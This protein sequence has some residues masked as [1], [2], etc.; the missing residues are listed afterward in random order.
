MNGPQDLGGFQGFGPVTPEPVLPI[1][2]AD[3]EKR[4]F[5][6]ALAM[7]MTGS[8]NID[9]SRHARERIP[10]LDYW[11][12]SYYEVWLRGLA[13]LLTEANLAS[14]AEIASG[15]SIGPAREVQRVARAEDI[16]AILAK[17]GP[18]NRPTA[19]PQLFA[20]GSKVRTINHHTAA[21]TRLPRYARNKTGEILRVHG[22]H[23]LPDSS[24]HGQD[25]GATWLYS[26][27]FTATELWGHSTHDTVIIDLWQP[28]LIPA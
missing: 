27:A 18:A 16:P 2:H 7:G 6:L 11:Q 4:A 21:H 28:Y 24:A 3:W 5:A 25:D 14:P 13:T 22:S 19:E 8:W 12:S 26:V 17:G 15:Q 23:V 20:V 9:T 10:V 1:F